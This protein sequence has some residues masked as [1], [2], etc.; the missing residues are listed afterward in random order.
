MSWRFSGR[1]DGRQYAAGHFGAVRCLSRLMRRRTVPSP[2]E[3]AFPLTLY[4][5]TGR[6][7]C[8]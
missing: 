5:H 4:L 1:Q 8:G 6:A 2:A 7:V 3:A